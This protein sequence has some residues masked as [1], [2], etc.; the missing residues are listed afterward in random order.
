MATFLLFFAGLFTKELRLKDEYYIILYHINTT[1]S[2]N[3]M[4]FSYSRE[5]QERVSP[6]CQPY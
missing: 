1:N 6:L 4:P 5:H 3:A 2:I